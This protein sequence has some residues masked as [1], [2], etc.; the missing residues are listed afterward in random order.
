MDTMEK[1]R[2]YLFG[3][4]AALTAAFV[5]L[6][7]A[8]RG[9]DVKVKAEPRDAVVLYTNDIH[10]GIDGYAKLAAYRR[11]MIEAGYETAVVD[12][13]DF[14]QGE[15]AGSLTKGADIVALMNAVPYDLAVPGNHEFDYGTANFLALVQKSAAFP[16]LSANFEDLRTHKPVLPPCKILALGGRQVAFVG[17]CTPS[18]YTSSTPKYFED[19][20]GRQIYGFGEKDFVA[21]VQAAVDRARKEGAE[22]VILLAHLGIN[23]INEDWRSIDVIARTRGIDAVIDGHSHEAFAGEVYKN[24]DGKDV[25]YSQTGSKFMFFGKMTLAK[26]GSIRT[27]LLHPGD[28]DEKKSEASQKAYADVQSLIDRCHEKVAYLNEKLG[29]AEV[30]L[31]ID[32]PRTGTRR[33][34]LGECSMGDFV[35]DAYRAVLGAQIAVVNGGGVRASVDGPDVTR[36]GLMNVNPWNNPTCVVEM[37]GQTLLDLLEFSCR[38]LPGEENGGFLQVSGLSFEVEPSLKSPVKIDDKGVFAGVDET[39]PRRVRNVRVGGGPLRPEAAYTVASSK[40]VLLEGG[41]GNGALAGVKVLKAE[42][43]PTDAECLVKYFTEDLHGKVK[44]EKY[45]NPLGSGRITIVE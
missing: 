33:V 36:L 31:A 25:R 34:R 6:L 27:E 12:A 15:M 38:H 21:K 1:S 3:G 19:E 8:G 2:K 11:Q 39:V 14:I 43:L 10:C 40:Y 13:G 24:A 37:P 44:M 5:L 9:Q 32:D 18:T 29:V 22:I 42:G 26:D 4:L 41:D 23:G 45:G 16:V 28:V 35:A 20:N 17:V 7:V 30:P